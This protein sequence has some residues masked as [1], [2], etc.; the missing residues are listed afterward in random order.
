MGL[1]A[2]ILLL[3][4]VPADTA[5]PYLVAANTMKVQ[6]LPADR[7][8]WLYGNVEIT[9][10]TTV[11]RG[12]SAWASTATDR[13]VVWGHFRLTDRTAVI[14]GHKAVYTKA[15]GRAVVH[16]DPAA[17]DN[18]WTMTADSIVFL[19]ALERSYAIGHV[20]LAD[21]SGRN[22]ATGD[23]GEYWH[24]RDYGRLTGRPRFEMAG[25]DS[26]GPPAVIIAD[27]M[28]IEQR[29][30]V[31]TGSG[32]VQYQGDSVWA[33]GG[34]L[35]YD[36]QRG[37]I[38]LERAPRVWNA[39]S[40]IRARR[41]DLEL[42]D[43]AVRTAWARDSVEMRQTAAATPDTDLIC[44]DSLWAEFAQRKLERAA[45][46]GRAWSRYHQLER[47]RAAGR[48]LAAGDRMDFAFRDGRI[49]RIS[50]RGG[51]RGAYRDLPRT[52]GAP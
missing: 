21:S 2:V 6:S 32:D 43:Q 10:G 30:A 7:V 47:E 34:R 41:I 26:A 51:A 12:D 22:R 37:R 16:G 45:V 3:A 8:T 44:G 38:A 29:G 27:T 1:N 5:Q 35:A 20:A 31:A 36:R 48:N 50:V 25:G 11:L 15:A 19:K 28:E 9:H 49:A 46:M 33:A 17:R 24:D 40:E 4:L 13:A 52:G 18:S 23:F 39:T 14:T 42:E